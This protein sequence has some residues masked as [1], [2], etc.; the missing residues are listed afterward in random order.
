[1]FRLGRDDDWRGSLPVPNIVVLHEPVLEP[2]WWPLQ[3]LASLVSEWPDLL[4][5]T[6]LTMEAAPSALKAF[7]GPSAPSLILCTEGQERGSLHGLRGP[8]GLHSWVSQVL[9]EERLDL[10]PPAVAL[11][12]IALYERLKPRLGRNAIEREMNLARLAQEPMTAAENALAVRNRLAHPD[13][14]VSLSEAL[15][16]ARAMRKALDALK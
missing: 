2:F 3:S 1:M 4:C 9:Y 6:F 8:T 5:V 12:V 11:Q 16:S 7:G 13:A 15:F 10:C 14:A